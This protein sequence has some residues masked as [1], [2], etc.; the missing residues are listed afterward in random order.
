MCLFKKKHILSIKMNQFVYQLNELNSG[1]QA[2]DIK[3]QFSCDLVNGV[4]RGTECLKESSS[5]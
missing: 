3:K 4:K 1:T 2:T 5:G